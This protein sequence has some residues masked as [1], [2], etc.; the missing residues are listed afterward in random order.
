M[1]PEAIS[2]AITA[3]TKVF[4][5]NSPNNP[6][7]QV[8]S[9]ESL[10]TLGKILEQKGIEFNRTIY[11]LSDEPYRKIVYD[12]IVVPSIFTAYKNSI[13]GTSYSKDISIPGERIGFIAVNP[14]ATYRE[15]L[16]A[17]MTVANRILGYVN[18]PALM[19]RVVAELQ[20]ASVDNTIY[21]RRREKFCK[22]LTEAGY[23][24]MP[25]KG[26][27][28]IFP[29]SPI[30]DDAVFVGMLQEQK[31]LAVPGKGFGAPGYFRLAFCVDDAVIDRSAEAFHRAMATVK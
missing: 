2:G 12:G 7:G 4:L 11:L 20:G 6:T 1:D 19:Q 29:R 8:Y 3:K 17:A 10:K 9:E 5:I 15:N 13:I 24:F 14:A 21:M 16:L 26:A 28:Y 22:I 31:I 30:A 18:A 25:P 23:D 27:F